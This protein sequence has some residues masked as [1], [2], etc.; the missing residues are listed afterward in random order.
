MRQSTAGCRYEV[1][2]GLEAET[3]RR[4]FKKTN[5]ERQLFVQGSCARLNVHG[6]ASQGHRHLNLMRKNRS[7]TLI[8]LM[9]HILHLRCSV[10]QPVIGIHS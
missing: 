4:F 3:E 7:C 8:L 2:G 5:D 6:L 10:I 9:L 1:M